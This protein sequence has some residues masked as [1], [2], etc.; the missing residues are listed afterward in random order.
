MLP[1]VI[2]NMP[3]VKNLRNL[4]PSVMP[5][6]HKNMSNKCQIAGP[7]N[8][9]LKGII[10]Y[11]YFCTIHHT[12]ETKSASCTSWIIY[13]ILGSNLLL[14]SMYKLVALTL[15]LVTLSIP[16][17]HC[18]STE[19]IKELREESKDMFYHAYNAYLF[20]AFPADELM[21]LTCQGESKYHLISFLSYWK[22]YCLAIF[23]VL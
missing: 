19:E 12:K 10:H 17:S 5:T 14:P 22:K 23:T 20:N 9:R 15:L 3:P 2:H 13:Y 16:H 18:M 1:S 11:I 7:S 8:H 21:P 4:Q 6:K